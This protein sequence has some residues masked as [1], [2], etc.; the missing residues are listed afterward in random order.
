MKA[1]DQ[2][3][4]QWVLQEITTS[5]SMLPI[6]TQKGMAGWYSKNRKPQGIY[7]KESRPYAWGDDARFIDWRA[8]A[9]LQNTYSKVTEEEQG[10]ELYIVAFVSPNWWAQSE[11]GT[12]Q[13][14]AA[15]MGG[16]LLSQATKAKDPVG[17]IIVNGEHTQIVKATTN[18]A[19]LT[20]WLTHI[21]QTPQAVEVT[22]QQQAIHLLQKIIPHSGRLMCLY[23][24]D[25]T[26]PGLLQKLFANKHSLASIH[27][28][29]SSHWQLPKFSWLKVQSLMHGVL[30]LQ[31]RVPFSGNDSSTTKHTFSKATGTAK[32]HTVRTKADIPV[33]FQTLFHA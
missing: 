5:Q 12:I 10:S 33:L 20:K 26:L 6:V 11:H 16:I 29:P 3:L 25:F 14:L 15:T 28:V 9:K 7:F 2:A 31:Q 8:T 1:V 13:T 19:T 32:V 22:T 30:S 24:E 4:Y 23:T 27:L 21:L 18:N 17:Y